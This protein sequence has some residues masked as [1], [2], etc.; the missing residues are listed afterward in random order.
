MSKLGSFLTAIAFVL[1]SSVSGMAQDRPVLVELFTSQGCSSCPPADAFLHELAERD[2]V[3]ALA[4]HV[5][6]WDYIGWKDTFASAEYTKRQRAYARE[7]NRRMIY[8]PQMVINGLDHVVGNRPMD[9]NELIQMHRAKEAR[10]ALDVARE[11]N[12]VQIAASADQGQGYAT[13][14]MVRYTPKAT[15][16]IRRGENAGRKISYANVVTEMTVVADWDMQSPLNVD[17]DVQGDEPV[18]VLVQAGRHGPVE[19]VARVN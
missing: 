14:R 13:V 1:S 3:V 8:T 17:V 19:A 9:V 6:Y 16:D 2:D 15:V 4:L 12:Q 5:D 18:V 10:V 7:A 11:G